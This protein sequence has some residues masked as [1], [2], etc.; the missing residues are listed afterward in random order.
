NQAADKGVEG[1]AT[2]GRVIRAHAEMQ[3][4]LPSLVHDDMPMATSKSLCQQPANP[5]Y[6]RRHTGAGDKGRELSHLTFAPGM[7]RSGRTAF[8]LAL[9]RA[10]RGHSPMCSH[11]ATQMAAIGFRIERATVRKHPRQYCQHFP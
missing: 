2:G 4:F 7:P 8:N 11:K 3:G 5:L 6:A 10:G 1:A 9:R